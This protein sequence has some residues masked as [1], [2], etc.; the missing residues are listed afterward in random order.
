MQISEA[1]NL[2]IPP[3]TKIC[4]TASL[5]KAGEYTQEEEGK[6]RCW[7]ALLRS[8]PAT[9]EAVHLVIGGGFVKLGMEGLEHPKPRY[10]SK[11]QELYMEIEG[12]SLQMG[13]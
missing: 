2:F 3:K 10:D 5:N 4:P 13:S 8:I 11:N 9:V 12:T 6:H 7:R 1:R